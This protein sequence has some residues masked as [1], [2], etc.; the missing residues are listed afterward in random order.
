MPPGPG[1]GGPGLQQMMHG[2]DADESITKQQLKR[3]TLRRIAR[4]ARPYRWDL[5]IF[6]VAA[7]LDAVITV[8][9]PVLLGVVIDRGVLPQRIDVVLWVAAARRRA[10]DLRRRPQLRPALVHRAGRRGPDLRPAHA[11]VQPRAAAAD[12][13]LHPGADRLAGQQAEQRRDR[14]AAGDDLDPGDHR[15]EH[16]A[17]DP[18]ARHDALLLLA[19]HRHRAGADPDVHHPGSPGRPPAAAADQGIDAARRRDGIDHDRAVQ[20]R[21]RDAGQAVRPAAGGG[22]SVRRAG[23]QGQGHRRGPGHVRQHAVHRAHPARVAVHRGDLRGGRR[24]RRP[25]RVPGRHAGLPRHAAQ[26]AVRADHRAVQR[27]GPRD[28]RPGQLRPGVRGA[29]PEAADRRPAGRGAARAAA[30]SNGSA[31][32]VRVSAGHRLRPRLVPLPGRVR[33]LA[34]VAGVHR[35][36]RA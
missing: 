30:Q 20:R 18:G 15:V 22:W 13:V 14:G 28:D 11:G 33:G 32:H 6:L 7:A 25:R 8:T 5:V 24:P 3:G 19:G 1:P 26:P 10:G 16:A 31:R 21:R 2:F 17:A 12:R 9:I 27:S 4:Y 29:R 36:A 34:R 35:P 23:G